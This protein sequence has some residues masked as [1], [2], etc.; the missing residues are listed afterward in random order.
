M[1]VTVLPET[2]KAVVATLL[3]RALISAVSIDSKAI[4]K[5]VVEPSPVA[6]NGEYDIIYLG[7]EVNDLI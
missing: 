2:E 5:A 6:V 7:I 3:I 1:K 4:V